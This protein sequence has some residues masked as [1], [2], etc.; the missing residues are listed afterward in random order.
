MFWKLD[1]FSK[2]LLKDYI[3]SAGIMQ[4]LLLKV[5]LSPALESSW[6]RSSPLFREVW[7][8]SSV[9]FDGHCLDYLLQFRYSHFVSHFLSCKNSSSKSAIFSVA[10]LC[11]VSFL[12]QYVPKTLHIAPS[13]CQIW[14]NIV[15]YSYYRTAGL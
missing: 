9:F 15:F 12:D 8:K 6:L 10:P 7:I 3:S 11:R 14:L 1:L 13:V 5:N 4:E 2:E